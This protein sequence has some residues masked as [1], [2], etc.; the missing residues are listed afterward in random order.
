MNEATT[1][2]TR[3]GFSTSISDRLNDL[4]F[5]ANGMLGF[6]IESEVVGRS[7]PLGYEPHARVTGSLGGSL[8]GALEVQL[9]AA[10]PLRP[11]SVRPWKDRT[12][13][14]LFHWGSVTVALYTRASALSPHNSLLGVVPTL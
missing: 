14:G 10:E 3:A 11:T 2:L 8:R 4:G 6:S 9:I 12:D 13:V 5:D 1:T 7:E